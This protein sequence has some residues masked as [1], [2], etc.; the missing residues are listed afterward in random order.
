MRRRSTIRCTIDL[1]LP[2]PTTD[3]GRRRAAEALAGQLRDIARITL[4]HYGEEADDVEVVGC[5]T[6]VMLDEGEP[7]R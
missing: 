6:G 4:Y 3:I 2:W 7:I 1:R 5:A